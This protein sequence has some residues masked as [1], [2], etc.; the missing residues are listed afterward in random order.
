MNT[1]FEFQK[2]TYD[3]IIN[4][5]KT[6]DILVLLGEKDSGKSFIS[7]E[8]GL[9]LND[10]QCL[11]FCGKPAL[12]YTDFGCF[13]KDFLEEYYKNLSERDYKKTI[14]KDIATSISN[15]IFL[16]LDNTLDSFLSSNEKSEIYDIIDFIK[17]TTDKTLV[18]LI[19]DNIEY[20]D[21]KTM[22][23]FYNIVASILNREITNAK[24]LIVLDQNKKSKKT[25]LEKEIVDSLVQIPIAQV[26]E[27]DLS[28]FVKKEYF[29]IA[30]NIPIKYLLD[31]KT[32]IKNFSTYYRETLET[33]SKEHLIVKRILYTLVL[34]DEEVSF[35]NLAIFISDIPTTEL[36]EGIESLKE[37]S[38]VEWYEIED[39]VYYTV[40]E[41]IKSIIRHDI[42]LYLSVNRYEMYAKQ[43][44]RHAPLDY[45]LK[46]WL[47]NKAE[48]IENAYANAILSYCS[49][50][51]GEA[52][53]SNEEYES[54]NRFLLDSSYRELYIVLSKAYRFYNT[55]DYEK[56][57]ELV[58][59]FMLQ[60]HFIEKDTV[61]FSVYI[62]EFVFE[63]LYVRGM[64]I[65]RLPNIDE[66]VISNHQRL[67]E[68]SIEII[69]C[70][71]VNS[72]LIQR[73]KEQKL[74]LKTYLSTQ[75][76][77][78][79]KDIYNEYFEIS[80]NYQ[81]YI[82]ES[83]LRTREKW[84]IRYASFLMKA[85][86]VAD[87]LDKLHILEK[88]YQILDS[89]KD[90]HP[91]KYLKAA[92]NLAGDYMWRDQY[93]TSTK[94]LQNAIQF[95]ERKKWF[96][97]WG[98]I[99]QMH[100]FSRLY[101]ENSSSPRDLF[102]EYNEKIWNCPEVRLKMHE[103]TIC[104]SNYAILLATIGNYEEANNLLEKTL[105]EKKTDWNYYNEYL[106]STNLGMIKYLMGD[107][108]KALELEKHCKD[109][110]DQKLVPTFSPA[111]IKKRSKIIINIYSHNKKIDNVLVPLSVQQTLSTG[112]CSD[113]YYRPLL[114][115]DINYWAD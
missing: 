94:L 21:N 74:L 47:Y 62:P 112:Y 48:N 39:N 68:Y 51:R 44:E 92:C 105:A 38:F 34:L 71:T 103:T 66:D 78:V 10:G 72:E 8:V 109:L 28:D 85:N 87:L 70:T 25:I 18:Y 3:N 110:I 7:K 81:L 79:Q 107:V 27:S 104:N 90:N 33:L 86:I 97:Y 4:N 100:I 59:N 53:C 29:S 84:Q 9:N 96:Q 108:E 32:D 75:S 83:N 31:L 69:K 98:I 82:R 55:N 40:P 14:T 45:V 106:L 58:N 46:Y 23:F 15:V 73:L 20:Y 6:E 101:G 30:Q 42:P 57:Y 111:F 91:V 65:G 16:S 61:F 37:N 24:L 67:L 49:I 113:N 1:L 95:I 52:I 17:K 13:P 80:S 60:N 102:Q 63:M 12:R 22:V 43:I 99:Y 54:F 5:F 50:A 76:R 56:C 11:S 88:G 64:C 2:I 93:E 115:S 41:L 89:K 35:N 77:K 19:F 36:Y 26:T 114:F